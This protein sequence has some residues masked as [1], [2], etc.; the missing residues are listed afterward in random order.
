M[1]SPP[2]L[3]KLYRAWLLPL[4]AGLALTGASQA[5]FNTA[6]P[7]SEQT[8]SELAASLFPVSVKLEQANLFLTAPR[9]LFIDSSRIGIRA[10]F[11]AYDHRPDEGVALS[12]TGL[13]TLSGRVSWDR[14]A[15]EVLLHDPRIEQLAFDRDNGATRHFSQVLADAW[16]GQVTNPIR[17]AL[18]PHP[19]LTPFRDNIGDILYDGVHLSLVLVY[20]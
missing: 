20:Q 19:Y 10:T 9:V 3:R 16:S 12:E 11:Q 18:P 1:T 2:G 14:N 5:A 17:S 13:A 15:R 4:L 8:A 7:V 6:V